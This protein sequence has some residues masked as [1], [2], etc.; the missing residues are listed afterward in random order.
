MT[1]QWDGRPENPH[2][3]GFFRLRAS[4]ADEVRT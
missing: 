2:H 4:K 3:D 1:E